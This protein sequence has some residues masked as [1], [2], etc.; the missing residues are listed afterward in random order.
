MLPGPPTPASRSVAIPHPAAPWL[1]AL[2]A[3]LLTVGLLGL[4]GCQAAGQPPRAV[5]LRL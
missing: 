2:L 1:S 3:L 5:L 4:G